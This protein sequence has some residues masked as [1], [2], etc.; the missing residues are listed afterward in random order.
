MAGAAAVGIDLGHFS[1]S[2]ASRQSSTI[3]LNPRVHQ[4]ALVEDPLRGVHAGLHERALREA[5]D[6]RHFEALVDVRLATVVLRE[7]DRAAGRQAHQRRLEIVQPAHRIAAAARQVRIARRVDTERP[8]VAAGVVSVVDRPGLVAEPPAKVAAADRHP[9]R[10]LVL[11]ADRV[12]PVVLAH[13]PT[14]SA[15]QD[16]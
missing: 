15:S 2:V 7:G 13:A 12:F 8:I 9:G 6:R 5:G 10:Q 4:V 1:P 3:S 14:R 16:R 11:R